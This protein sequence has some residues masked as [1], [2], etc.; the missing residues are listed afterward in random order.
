[1]ERRI[2]VLE[3]LVGIIGAKRQAETVRRR[4]TDQRRSAHLHRLDG[5][6]HIVER[7]QPHRGKAMRQHGL[8]DDAD[9]P[10]VGF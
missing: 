5:A 8:I 7:G 9:R 6:C 10:A 3:A 1:V 2:G 4:G